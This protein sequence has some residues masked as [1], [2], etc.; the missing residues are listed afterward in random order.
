MCKR[1]EFYQ[2]EDC[3]RGGNFSCIGVPEE[4]QDVYH[5][6]E[7]QIASLTQNGC[8]YLKTVRRASKCCPLGSVKASH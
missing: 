3:D 6:N 4:D 5:R 2:K 1:D 7:N 8:E